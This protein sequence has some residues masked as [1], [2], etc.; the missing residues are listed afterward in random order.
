[1][2]LPALGNSC[3]SLLPSQTGAFALFKIVI[4]DSTALR[5]AQSM[6]L[7]GK[8]TVPGIQAFLRVEMVLGTGDGV[9]RLAFEDG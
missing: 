2:A 6:K 1:M 4:D 8:G 5:G 3:E 9:I 7:D